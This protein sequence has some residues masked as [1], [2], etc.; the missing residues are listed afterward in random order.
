MNRSR[1]N[2]NKIHSNQFV[3]QKYHHTSCRFILLGILGFFNLIELI[4]N[5]KQEHKKT[6][7]ET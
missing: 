1:L 7:K 2:Y 6:E 3:D 4:K 5:S